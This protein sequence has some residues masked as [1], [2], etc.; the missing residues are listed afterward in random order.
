MIRSAIFL[1]LF[2]V[3]FL[4][5]QP[6]FAQTCNPHCTSGTHC[7]FVGA[8]ETAST[9]TQCI[10]NASADGTVDAITVTAAPKGTTFAGIVNGKIVPFV[11]NYIIPLLYILAFL[12]FGGG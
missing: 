1:P 10:P 11:N 9:P 8:D 2:F 5:A 4:F 7:V 12:F 3:L 6:A